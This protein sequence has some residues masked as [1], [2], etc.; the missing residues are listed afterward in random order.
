MGRRL[1]TYVLLP[2]CSLIVSVLAAEL[3]L[4]WSGLVGHGGVFTVNSSEFARVPGIFAPGQ[5][6]TVRDIRQLPYRVTIDSLGYRGKDFSRAKE[7]EEFRIL[8]VGDSFV[9]GDFVNDA[10]T[11]PARL[12]QE[13]RGRCGAPIRVINA[14]LGGSSITEHTRMIE[15]GLAIH[16]DLVILQF[17]E[18]DVTDLAGPR[19][20]DLLAR[21]RK[22][23]SRFPL[24]VVYPAVRGTALWNL[25]LRAQHVWR[26]RRT[27]ERIGRPTPDPGRDG[28][29]GGVYPP[30]GGRDDRYRER[31]RRHLEDGAKMLARFGIPWVFAVYPSHHSVYGER[32]E[33]LEWVDDIATDLG[34]EVV[35]YS[36]VL[37]ADGRPRTDLYLLPWD[38]HPSPAGYRLAAEHLA[39]RLG[40]IGVLPEGCG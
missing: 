16:P 1:V 12:E 39:A 40:S 22:A 25:V 34:L 7:D 28:P 30:S 5:E 31:Y 13:L 27:A 4:R 29:G 17:S 32:S 33:Q 6:S 21:N 19:M 15:R 36:A 38:G 2:T 18:T 10:E 37:S 24:S 26:S 23:K 8:F 35:S 11:L 14:G 20:W 9:F 3:A